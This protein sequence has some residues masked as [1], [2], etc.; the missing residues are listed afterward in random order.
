[1]SEE[2]DDAYGE[3]EQANARIYRLNKENAALRERVEAGKRLA[4]DIEALLARLEKAGH[5][6]WPPNTIGVPM[7]RERIA[8]V[9]GQKEESHGTEQQH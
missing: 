4:D 7:I 9:R 2:L 1:M 3:L 5:F 6:L 8:K